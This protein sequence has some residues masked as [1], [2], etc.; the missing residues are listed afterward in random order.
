MELPDALNDE[1]SLVVRRGIAVLAVII[2][3]ACFAAA[4]Y[5]YALPDQ[6]ISSDGGTHE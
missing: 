2:A 5:T 6:P 1:L 4:G 3:A